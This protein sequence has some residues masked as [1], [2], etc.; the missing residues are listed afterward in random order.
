MREHAFPM[1]L[2]IQSGPGSAVGIVTGYGLGGPGIESQ[3][4]Q[5][6]P[7]LSRTALGPTHPPVQ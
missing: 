1:Q 4:G 6:I 2:G 5:D 3:W 7:R